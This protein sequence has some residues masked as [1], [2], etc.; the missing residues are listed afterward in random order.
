[1]RR[2]TVLLFGGLCAL[3][4]GCAQPWVTPERLDRGLVVVL[5]GIEGRSPLNEAICRGLDAG[6]VDWA[7]RLEDWTS[8]LGPLYS[9]R[10]EAENRRKARHLAMEISDYRLSH[11][12]RPVV[13]VGQSG[14]GAMAAWVAEALPPGRRI[15]GI[16]MIAPALSPGYVL[17]EA[18]RKSERGI[19]NFHSRRDW[20]MLGMGTFLAGTMDGY[21]TSSAGRLGFDVP[22]PGEGLP[23]YE[24]LLQIPWQPEMAETG[25]GGGHLSSAEGAF[26]A[27]YV[28]PFVLN[29]RWDE[30]LV[31]RIRVS[32]PVEA[33][34]GR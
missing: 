25:Y 18:L 19:V 34:P 6:G 12:D 26:V 9:L 15:D 33:P 4:A 10:A 32:P 27:R 2:I 3:L 20:F 1:M 28:A 22:E 29:E 23:A 24:K 14:G 13:L 7:I 30:A 5:T 17:S 16:V 8:P 31:E 21:H 11:P